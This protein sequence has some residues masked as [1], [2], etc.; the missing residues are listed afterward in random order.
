M[1]EQLFRELQQR[2]D[3]Y[4]LGFP[5]TESGIEIKILK[6]LF[7]VDD[8]KMFLTLTPMMEPAAAVAEKMGIPMEDAAGRLE[9]MAG[10]GLLFRLQKNGVPRYGAIPFIHGLWE[11]QIKRLDSEFAQMTEQYMSEGL[12]AAM[13]TSGEFFLRTIPVGESVDPQYQVASYDDACEILRTRKLIV[14]TDCICRK[15]KSMIGDNCG[16]PLEVCF[17]FGSMGQYYLDHDMGREVTVEEAE[18]LLKTA[19]DAGLVTQ[20]A[21]AQNPGGMCNCCGDCCGVLRVLNMHPKPAEVVFSNHF[22]VVED[23]LCTACEACEERCQMDA[24][25]VKDDIGVAVVDLDRC[26]GC[27]LCVTDCPGEALKLIPKNE[28]QWRIPPATSM[29]Q[30]IAMAQKR[31]L[32]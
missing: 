25:S 13:T 8:V 12:D 26:I 4:S 14:A 31:G 18:R 30:M 15:Q 16:K 27:G 24:I 6:H 7:S 1:S 17:M 19:R 20:P 23:D 10:R 5:A 32:L 3:T 22:A 9:D 29:D 11:F 21:T 2:L 28:E